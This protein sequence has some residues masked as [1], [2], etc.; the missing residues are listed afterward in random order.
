[1][2]VLIVLKIGMYTHHHNL[3]IHLKQEALI[4]VKSIRIPVLLC[5]RPR[6]R[7]LRRKLAVLYRV[8]GLDVRAPPRAFA[9]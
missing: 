4:R 7:D 8:S 6:V 2:T 1:M 3:S 5:R 9:S